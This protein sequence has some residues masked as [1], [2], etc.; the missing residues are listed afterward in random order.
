MRMRIALA[1]LAA[2]FCV[3]TAVATVTTVRQVKNVAS[4]PSR[5]ITRI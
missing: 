4:S 1:V 2:A 3:A 5:P